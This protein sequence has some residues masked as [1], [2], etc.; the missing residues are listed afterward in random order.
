MQWKI[1]EKDAECLG[2]R[3]DPG[4]RGEPCFD[5]VLE[6]QTATLENDASSITSC[7]EVAFSS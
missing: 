5:N 1:I 3:R 6:E 2:C 4:L 7:Y